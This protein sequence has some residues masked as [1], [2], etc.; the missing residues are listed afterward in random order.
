[1]SQFILGI[2]NTLYYS[3]GQSYLDD[4]TKKTNTPLMLAYAYSL[5][6]FGPML[7]FVLAY[8]FLN[9]YIDPTMTPV[10]KNT[11]PR[12]LGAWWLGWIVLGI[13]MILISSLIGFFPRNMPKRGSAARSEE[14]ERIANEKDGE[15]NGLV[16]VKLIEEKPPQAMTEEPAHNEKPKLRDFPVALKR[17]LMNKL[18]MFNIL[19]GVFYILGSGGYITFLAKYLE[20]QFNKAK[21][22]STIVAGPLSLLGMIMGL[23][24]S[25]Y[26]IAKKKPHPSKLL[27]WNVFIGFA[28]LIGQFC[29]LF[30]S[31]ADDHIPIPVNGQLNLTRD[32]NFNCNCDGAPYSP[33]CHE[34]SGTTFF[35][36]CH[37]GCL[38]WNNTG[39]LYSNCSCTDAQYKRS[40][41]W[42]LPSIDDHVTTVYDQTTAYDTTIESWAILESDEWDTTPSSHL[43]RRKREEAN[44]D[45]FAT[46][47]GNL[48]VTPGACMA[49]CQKSFLIFIIVSSIINCLGS[50][51]KIGNILVNY[52]VVTVEDKSFSQGLMLMM[53]SLFA[54]IPGPILYGWI[55]DNT[56]LI[57]NYKCNNELGNCQLYDKRAFRINMNLVGMSEYQTNYV[58][59][60]EVINVI[61]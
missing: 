60:E 37:A 13:A 31:C 46:R 54:L 22:D 47:L 1:M 33:V 5:R 53:I 29:Y 48:I 41:P 10:I 39:Q 52:R 42:S 49:G 27:G 26:I 50:S 17:L 19:S 25:G 30:L 23:M 14:G 59:Q 20:V 7:G 24:G 11:D 9:M 56:C 36:A 3:L 57:W 16:E 21:S 6:M 15:S 61:F 45:S 8:V 58:E 34:P 35:S 28:Y 12:W 40:N 18:L 55:I 32:C 44:G 51:G 4:N 2:G 43:D 38:S